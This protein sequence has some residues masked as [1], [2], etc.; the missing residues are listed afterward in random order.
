MDEDGERP[1]WSQLLG[2]HE[3]WGPM[4]VLL[5]HI[6]LYEQVHVRDCN[7]VDGGGIGSGVISKDLWETNACVLIVCSFCN[8][9]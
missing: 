2:P 1:Q 4:L 5:E 8:V 9:S 6:P 3:C 7:H